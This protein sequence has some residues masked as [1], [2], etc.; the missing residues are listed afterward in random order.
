MKLVLD[1]LCAVKDPESSFHLYGGRVKLVQGCFKCGEGP[2]KQSSPLW[3][4]CK[5]RIALFMTLEGS[6][7]RFV[8]VEDQ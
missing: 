1:C 8:T 3:K 7:K 6:R 2:T 5:A 4:S